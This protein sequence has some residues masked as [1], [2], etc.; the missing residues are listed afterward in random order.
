MKPIDFPVFTHWYKTLDWILQRL[1]GFPKDVRFTIAN[2]IA[3][4]SLDI[5]EGIVEAIYTKDRKS[6]LQG[7]NLRLEKLRILFRISM[8][9]QY[10]SIKQHEYISTQI[11]E[12]GRMIGGWMKT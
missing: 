4:L 5:L 10:I 11:N 7:V 2:R 3:S 1:E 12:T 8:D 9:R 6:I